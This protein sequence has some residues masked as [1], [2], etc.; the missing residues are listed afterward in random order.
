MTV[1]QLP[2]SQ[3]L[4]PNEVRFYCRQAQDERWI[5][6]ISFPSSVCSQL[7]GR[8]PTIKV[9]SI[10]DSTKCSST[11]Q[12]RRSADVNIQRPLNPSETKGTVPLAE[13]LTFL[14]STLE[15]QLMSV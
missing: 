2:I 12:I 6:A 15:Y 8:D 4:P 5:S 3:P 10:A 9:K 13:V 14:D 7:V 11:S 1:K